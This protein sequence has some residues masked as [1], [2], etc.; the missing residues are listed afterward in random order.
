MM[1]KRKFCEPPRT[2]LGEAA[3]PTRAQADAGLGDQLPQE[4]TAGWSQEERIEIAYSS[5]MRSI[6]PVKELG[7]RYD[8][9]GR[10]ER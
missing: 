6:G 5:T 9:S 10:K 4:G 3:G 7:G 8:G 1:R 2:I